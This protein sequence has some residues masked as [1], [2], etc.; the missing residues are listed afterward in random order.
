LEGAAVRQVS[1]DVRSGAVELVELPFPAPAA[2]QVIIGTSVSLMSAG[3]ERMLL[4]FGQA[5]WLDKARQQPDRVREVLNK[6]RVDGLLPTI[7][8]VR[9]KLDQP[10][11]LGYC[12]AGRILEL[13]DGV[14]AFAVGDRVVSNG[15]HAEVVR[16]PWTLCARI[17]DEVSD[18]SASFAVLGAIALQGVRLAEPSIG[19]RF[20]VIGL[21]LVGLL[22]CQ[23]LSA[24]GCRVLGCDFDARRLRLARQFGADT[25]DLSG[26][27]DPVPWVLEHTASRG[28]DGVIIAASTESSSPVKQAAQ[29]SRRRGRIVLVGVAGL[30]LSRAD[31][32][33]K[34]ISFQVSCSYGPGRYDPAYEQGGHDYPL[35]FVRWTAQRN[36]E[37]MLAMLAS[38]RVQVEPLITNRYSFGE[39]AAAYRT[40]VEDTGALGIVLEY[41]RAATATA[42]ATAAAAWPRGVRL[43]ETPSESGATARVAVF[44][45]GNYA[46]R[47]LI[48][49]FAKAGA[50]LEVLVNTGSIRAASLGR[51]HGFAALSS[52]ADAVLADARINTVVIATRHDSH[53][54]LAVRALE[55][56]KHVFVEKPLAIGLDEL[57]SVEL[58]LERRAARAMPQFCVGFNRRFAPL[59]LRMRDLLARATGPM[60]LVYTVNAGAIPAGHWTQD[61][62]SGGGRIVGECCHFIDLLRFLAGSAI[63]SVGVQASPRAGGPRD[64][65]TVNLRFTDGSIGT[66]HYFANGSKAYPK[67][68][69]E[70]FR[71]GHTLQLDNFRRLLAFGFGTGAGARAWRQD[72]GQEPMIREFVRRVGSGGPQLIDWAQILDVTQ[73]SVRAQ[74]MV[75]AD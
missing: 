28:A 22:A 21:G 52:D 13:G 1:L 40:L 32:Y 49:G 67:E 58:S 25:L 43:R 55:A 17:P 26:G 54:A 20:A 2:R 74:Q 56:G 51:K 5:G 23:I 18:E 27:A 71:S 41:P 46:S 62:Q 16:V 31:F 65:A 6:I 53:A 15:A 11:A 48:P 3:T 24:A 7:E 50:A 47:V 63:E 68:R 29:M 39:S 61:P 70:A 60:S 73:A 33:E 36:F 35:G 69:V 9:A 57:S 14:G 37:A 45:A 66:V 4:N 12:N 75:D 64:T 59:I 10:I 44:G 30:E 42:T 34:E 72:K 38:G 19:E 8:A